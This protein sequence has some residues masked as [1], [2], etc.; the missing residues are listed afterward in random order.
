VYKRV[1]RFQSNDGFSYAQTSRQFLGKK[2][3]NVRKR[4]V[5][6][7]DMDVLAP[8]FGNVKLGKSKKNRS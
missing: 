2:I 7:V 1:I 5:T 8:M 3:L 4:V 6:V